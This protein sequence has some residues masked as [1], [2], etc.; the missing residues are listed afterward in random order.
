VF[1][2]GQEEIEAAQEMLQ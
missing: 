1:F 2:T